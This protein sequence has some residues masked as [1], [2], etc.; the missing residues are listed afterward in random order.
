MS[1]KENK[2]N[3]QIVTEIE[4]WPISNFEIYC[5]L[6]LNRDSFLFEWYSD[7]CFQEWSI[8]AKKF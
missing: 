4:N 2:Q 6:L 1:Q 5:K 3:F 7:F 8:E